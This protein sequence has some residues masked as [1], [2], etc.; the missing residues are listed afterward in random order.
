[1][2]G[3]DRKSGRERI[4]DSEREGAGGSGR[5]E[6]KSEGGREW[7]KSERGREWEK[8]IETGRKR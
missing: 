5:E 6:G 1:M 8:E 7:G 3:S 2:G 4:R